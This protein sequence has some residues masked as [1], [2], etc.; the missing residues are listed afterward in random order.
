[1]NYTVSVDIEPENG[2]TVSGDSTYTIDDE[3]TLTATP[4][5][6]NEFVN[7]TDNEGNEVSDDSVYTFTMPS[8]D[9]SLTANFDSTQTDI[10]ERE[11]S[12]KIDIYPNP[13]REKVNIK[14]DSKINR[15][16]IY[17]ITGSV[18]Y[19]R[20][21][22]DMKPRISTAEFDTGLYILRIYTGEGTFEKKLQIRK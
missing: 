10:W 9:V 11:V 15:A 1:E 5:E 17:D 7:W 8:E 12:G 3:V 21:I 14:A 16:V 6:G 13:A 20:T 19:N 2:G 4:N 18:V 22:N